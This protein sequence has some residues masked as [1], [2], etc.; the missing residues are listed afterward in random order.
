MFFR[1]KRITP[2]ST[3]GAFSGEKPGGVV[4]RRR[5]EYGM[6][7]LENFVNSRQLKR[8]S[9]AAGALFDFRKGLQKV[10][11]SS[12]G[13]KRDQKRT[14]SMPKRGTHWRAGRPR[15]RRFLS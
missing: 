6:S 3:E 12:L 2:I 5:K 13:E 1:A 10:R 4:D 14:E 11:R 15:R 8:G 7:R 9:E